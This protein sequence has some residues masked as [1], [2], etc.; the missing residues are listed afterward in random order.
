MVDWYLKQVQFIPTWQDLTAEELAT[1]LLD[2]V[3]SKTRVPQLIMS[4]WDHLF[5]SWF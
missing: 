2:K 3:F 5:T 1:T 4:D